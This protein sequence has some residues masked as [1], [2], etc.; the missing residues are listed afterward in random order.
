MINSATV[1]PHQYP[2]PSITKSHSPSDSLATST[3]SLIASS[4]SVDGIAPNN[5]FVKLI[6]WCD[7]EW[8]Y[9][10]VYAAKVD[11]VL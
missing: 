7:N 6:E 10:L 8:G 1:E 5:R 3:A 4:A 2:Q 9:L 11:G